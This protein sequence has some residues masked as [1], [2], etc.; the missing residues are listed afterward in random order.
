ME[1]VSDR[2]IEACNIEVGKQTT[3]ILT[4]PASNPRRDCSEAK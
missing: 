1:E 2:F 3:L 4:I